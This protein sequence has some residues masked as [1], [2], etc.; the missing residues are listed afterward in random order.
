M[1]QA[2][3]KRTIAGAQLAVIHVAKARL[4]LDDEAYRDLLARVAGVRSS[5]QLAPD[6]FD[7]VMAEFRRLGFVSTG[8]QAAFGQ[9]PWPWA[10]AGQ[11]ARIR[12][13][14]AGFTDGR[15]DDGSLGRWMENRG[16]PPALRFLDRETAAKAM[17]A[18]QNMNRRKEAKPQ[19][20]G[21]DPAASGPP[22]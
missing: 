14:W 2:K 18:L 10:T 1:A 12:R 20:G 19:C 7:A 15:G 3:R 16:W 5:K 8:H 9:R 17:T 22:P 4:G 11:I 21:F 13:L 6:A